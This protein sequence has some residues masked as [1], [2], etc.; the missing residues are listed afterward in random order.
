MANERKY[1][2]P[3]PPIVGDPGTVLESY[4]RAVAGLRAG[5]V[6]LESSPSYLMLTG[7]E[8]GPTTAAKVGR[9]AEASGELWADLAAVEAALSHIAEYI[10]TNGTRGAHGEEVERL[11]GQRWITVGSST[12]PHAIVEILDEVRSTYDDIRP[13]VDDV[14]HL[15]L[16]LLPRI[17]AAK[18]TLARLTGEA[19]R[20]GLPE[21]LIGRA[22]ALVADLEERLVAD[23]LAV[24]IGDGDRLDGQV[25]E[26]AAQMAST[27]A[28]H[29]SLDEDLGKTEELLAE[30]RVLRARAEAS[31]REVSAKVSGSDP[32]QVPSVAVLDGPGGL[33]E[34]LD[35][36]FDVGA[37]AWNQR[38]GLL[39]SWL[40]TA[41]RLEKQLRRATEAN[42]EPLVRR[43]ELRGRLKAY[44]AKV[45][46]L[47]RAE[48][49][50]LADVVDAARS[51]LY[52]APSDLDR[53]AA[54]IEDLARKLRS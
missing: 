1:Q 42:G 40:S 50:A 52:T 33:A 6:D 8:L 22:S 41:E 47:G 14:E 51:E 34:R 9:T 35:R 48:D 31:G 30:L 36:L 25:A 17:D 21:P 27:L 37:V 29:D 19:E 7:D 53:A 44:Q 23:P 18:T 11:L 49:L 10:E 20:L 45:S 24:A 13:L 5:L 4:Q 38:R 39:D 32:V 2:T 46:A 12:Q 54:T 16:A 15:W 43:D 26:A 3:P 28:A